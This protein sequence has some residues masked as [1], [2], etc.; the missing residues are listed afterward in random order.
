MAD[1]DPTHTPG[2]MRGEDHASGDDTEPQGPT[3]RPAGQ[4]EGDMM[5]PEK[6]AG[7]ME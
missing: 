7:I 3:G 4:V 6:H 5:D 1:D 2:T